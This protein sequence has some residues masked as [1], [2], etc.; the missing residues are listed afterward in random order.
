MLQLAQDCFINAR[1]PSVPT[2]PSVQCGRCSLNLWPHKDRGVDYPLVEPAWKGNNGNQEAFFHSCAGGFSI[3]AGNNLLGNLQAPLT[4]LH[5]G[6][7]GSQP[8][9][10]PAYHRKSNLDESRILPAEVACNIRGD[11]WAAEHLGH[12]QQQSNL[13]STVVSMVPFGAF[14][15][16]VHVQ[17]TVGTGLYHSAT[18]LFIV[19]YM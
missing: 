17:G 1:W 3:S 15:N 10:H 16:Y 2:A 18:V 7:S 13:W 9:H 11:G 8:Y 12:Q 5:G 14:C 6:L 19:I 4:S